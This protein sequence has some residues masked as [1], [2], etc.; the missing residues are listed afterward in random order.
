MFG[1][2]EVVLFVAA[3]V[4]LILTFALWVDLLARRVMGRPAR[5]D[6]FW[7][8]LVASMVG[9]IV[10]V[11]GLLVVG[12]LHKLSGQ[13][14]GE[15]SYAEAIALSLRGILVGLIVPFLLRDVLRRMRRFRTWGLSKP[16]RAGSRDVA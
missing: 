1:W 13:S 2:I 9:V 11:V 10:L 6:R 3:G 14:V 7:L 15:F 4:A 12:L 16:S 5:G 8:W